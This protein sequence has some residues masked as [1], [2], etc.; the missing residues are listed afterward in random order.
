MERREFLSLTLSSLASLAAACGSASGGEVQMIDAPEGR[1]VR[2]EKDELVVLVSGIGVR[3]AP[4]DIIRLTVVVNNQGH[5]LVQARVRTKL[6]G[7]GM[8]PVVE[9]PVASL[10]VAPEA[11]ASVDRELPVPTSLTPGDYT[12]Q[13]ELPPWTVAESRHATGGG[14]LALALRVGG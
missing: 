11:A 5:K 7:R 1:V 10:S 6:L 8:Q 2:W 9:A 3:Y 12:L 14:K 13:I 4:G